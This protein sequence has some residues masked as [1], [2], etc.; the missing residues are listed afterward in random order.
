MRRRDFI[1]VLGSAA[2][3]TWP[4]LAHAQQSERVHL[5]G[6]WLS[7]PED[8]P[9]V[10]QQVARLQDELA[11]LGWVEGR[12]IRI[13]YRFSASGDLDRY[14]A[15]AKDLVGLQ[16]ELIVTQTTAI[17]AALQRETGTIPIVFTR[18]SDPIGSGLV[19]SFARPSGNLT[20][21]LQY[22]PGIMG[23]WLAMLK[24]IAPRITNVRIEVVPSP[25]SNDTDIERSLAAFAQLTNAGSLCHQV[26]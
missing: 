23:K 12:T 13:E 5:I 9:E 6:V 17:T 14:P 15:V 18:V 19:S 26:S 2:A 11:K 24:E 7:N 22:E 4:F 16:P 1:T 25:V 8:D 20:G 10:R 3:V 21:L